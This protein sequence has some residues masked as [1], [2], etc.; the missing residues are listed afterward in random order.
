MEELTLTISETFQDITKYKVIEIT[1][2]RGI[3]PPDTSSISI[4]LE[5]DNGSLFK[6]RY[7]SLIA[8]NLIKFVNTENFSI[9]GKSL[10]TQIL[11]RLASDGVK[12]GT[13]SG[14]PE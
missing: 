13:I 12:V 1:F 2:R 8:W 11:E 7:E 5:G 9:S 3:N 10:N 14:D 6:H 4:F